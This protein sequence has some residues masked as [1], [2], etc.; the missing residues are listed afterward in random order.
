MLTS[1][2]K[3][4]SGSMKRASIKRTISGS[5][6][7]HKAWIEKHFQKRDCICI[8][9][10]SKDPQRCCCG[11]LI[12]QHVSISP[13]AS[14][15]EGGEDDKQLVQSEKWTP[16]KHTQTSPTDAFGAMEFQGGGHASKAMYIRVS[17]DTKPELLL[18]LMTT[19]WELELPKLLI[20][21]HGG[22]QNFELQPKLKQVFGKGLIKAAMTTGAW[23]F[24]AGVDTGVIRH[25]G[26]ALKD[27][28]SKSCGRI[29]AIGFAPWGIVENKM[30]LIGKDI[31][32]PYQTMSNPLSKLTVLS[33]THSHFILSDNGSLGKYGAE[34]RLRRQLER[35]ISLQKINT[36]LGQG[37]PVV[38]LI[39]EGGPNVISIVLE[40]LREDP[41]VP[42]V[43][44]DGSGRASDILAFAHKYS[45]EG[46][47]ISETVRDQLMVTVQKT[48]NY[49]RHQAQQLF[50]SIMECMKKKALV[51]PCGENLF[52]DDGK[53]LPPCIPGA[54]I[55]PAI[56]ACYLLVANVLLVNLLIA[57][58]NNTFLEV[59]SIS[60]QVWKFQRYQLILTFHE[61]PVFP[62][63]LIIFSYLSM[64]AHHFCRR[65]SK[66]VEERD[67]GLKLILSE[68]EL[69]KLQEFEEQCVEQYFTQKEDQEQSSNDERIRITAE[70]VENMAM[71]LEEVN[72]R[73]H[74]MK[75][76]LQTVD[77]RLAQLEEF[78]G[79]MVNAM[80]KLAGIDKAELTHTRSRCPSECDASY[81][82][83]QNSTEATSMY[84]F[85]MDGD[86]NFED[87]TGL[88]SPSMGSQRKNY[89]TVALRDEKELAEQKIN[90]TPKRRFGLHQSSSSRRMKKSSLRL[91][92]AQEARNFNSCVDIFV[93]SDGYPSS[94]TTKEEAN[95]QRFMQAV[96][97]G[98]NGQLVKEAGSAARTTLKAC[99]SFPLEK[100]KKANYIPSQTYDACQTTVVK[101][102]SIIFGLEGMVSGP[103]E[104]W[105]S[106]CGYV[107]DHVHSASTS[108]PKT[109]EWV[110][111]CERKFY[112]NLPEERG[113]GEDTNR[114]PLPSSPETLA[115]QKQELTD[116][117]DDIDTGSCTM[118][119]S[120]PR[121]EV[122]RT[123]P[124]ST[125]FL[126]VTPDRFISSR[127]KSLHGHSRK[128][129]PMMEENFKPKQAFSTKDLRQV[130]GDPP[131]V[132]RDPRQ[133]RGDPRQVYGDP[134]QVYKDPRRTGSSRAAGPKK[135]STETFC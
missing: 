15:S 113:M 45:A 114:Q 23:I 8:I 102:R 3:Q 42:V 87:S 88:M 108:S 132:C 90:M 134:R 48:F 17:Y 71:R 54:W 120:L 61:R 94:L 106:D 60:N 110:T 38:C 40:S 46:G 77:I 57:V 36:R 28:S 5:Q 55:I 91:E 44:C 129:T 74:F 6:K 122:P 73:E 34:V 95:Y 39:V 14:S 9:P 76:S 19:E 86:D 128:T 29:C 18:Q 7:G 100:S 96:G 63:P 70:R 83:R 98:F 109:P 16:N 97:A 33:N 47:I 67:R 131:Q 81:L 22:L 56:M 127:S 119:L 69:K 72:E 50:V 58:F 133:V 85:H 10:N 101:A 11:Q 64:I 117:E 4:I 27:H 125:N 25:V 13:T 79:R 124:K 31:T 103:E 30:D 35:H 89:S 123:V 51:T 78:S 135:K 130:C 49:S 93:S 59:I 121:A 92:V 107:I 1:S 105:R 20:S 99:F 111:Q 66:E 104:S 82:I 52:D 37:V 24:T 84:R 41:P 62:P 112:K 68:E 2:L 43:V 75:A 32:K 26:D 80:E 21:V 118:D 65:K 12:G 126:T 53:R 115:E 116:T